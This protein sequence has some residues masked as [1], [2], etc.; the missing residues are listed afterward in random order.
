MIA[1]QDQSSSEVREES[2][3]GDA[4]QQTAV[5][6]LRNADPLPRLDTD[7]DRDRDQNRA[8]YESRENL[9]PQL[10]E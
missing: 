6:G 4:E 9:E 8:V 3:R 5:Y 2:N 1:M 10:A 7:A